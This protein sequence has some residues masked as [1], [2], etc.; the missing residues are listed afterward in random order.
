MLILGQAVGDASCLPNLFPLKQIPIAWKGFL[1][2]MKIKKQEGQLHPRFHNL[3]LV[4]YLLWFR[5]SFVVLMEKMFFGGVDATM[6]S[7]GKLLT[8]LNL[9]FSLG[10]IR[11]LHEIASAMSQR[12][13]FWCSD[14]QQSGPH[15]VWVP[16]ISKSLRS[17]KKSKRSGP[18]K[19]FGEDV[20]TY[21]RATLKFFKGVVQIPLYLN[22]KIG[23][24]ALQCNG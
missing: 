18:C 4:D 14:C 9:F 20:A 7:R 22:F 10:W 2:K 15:A 21:L 1:Q 13:F 6:L 11:H 3:R 5:D 8:E 16:E 19:I 23:F 12:G 24:E 17:R